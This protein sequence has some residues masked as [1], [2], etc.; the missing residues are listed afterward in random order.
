MELSETACTGTG[1][2]NR[3]GTDLDMPRALSDN[4]ASAC[5]GDNVSSPCSALAWDA[6]GSRCVCTVLGCAV[7]LSTRVATCQ[8][9]DVCT[10]QGVAHVPTL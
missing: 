8:A 9:E 10:A 6:A 2:V 3:S 1:A 4:R 5:T 7:Q